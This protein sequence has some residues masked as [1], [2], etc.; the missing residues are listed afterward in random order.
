[1]TEAI[2]LTGMVVSAI[3]AMIDR[4]QKKQKSEAERV[5]ADVAAGDAAAA[6]ETVDEVASPVVA[7]TAGG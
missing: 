2:V 6:V 5:A 1:M 3:T 7:A 4:I